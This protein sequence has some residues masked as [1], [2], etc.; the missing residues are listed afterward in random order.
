VVLVLAD[1]PRLS[2]TVGLDVLADMRLGSGDG[3]WAVANAFAVVLNV[4]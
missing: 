4:G 3:V 2:A 1:G